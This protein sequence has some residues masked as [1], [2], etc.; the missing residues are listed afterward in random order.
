[1]KGEAGGKAQRKGFFT[2]GI[3]RSAQT[4]RPFADPRNYA[5][6]VD[7][8]A[9]RLFDSVGEGDPPGRW[10]DHVDQYWASM[11]GNFSWR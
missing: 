8:D 9:P 5:E 7:W 4:P 3:P 2:D 1:M 6:P 10:P 11:N